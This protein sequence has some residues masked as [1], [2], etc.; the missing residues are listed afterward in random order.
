MTEDDRGGETE[1]DREGKE[2]KGRTHTL[3][4]SLASMSGPVLRAT[5]VTCAP[6]AASLTASALPKPTLPP[7]IK[8]CCE[9]K[10]QKKE[11]SEPRVII[12][13]Q[14][15]FLTFPSKERIFL[16]PG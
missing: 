1:D 2:E 14:R 11:A 16:G 13:S 10:S 3:I 4:A 7:V 6:S 12:R 5:M 8:T 15:F 9:R